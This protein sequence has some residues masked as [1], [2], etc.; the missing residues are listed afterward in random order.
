MDMSKLTTADKRILIA[1]VVVLVGGLVSIIDAWGIGG[2]VGGLAALGVVAVILQPQLSPAMKL[3]APKATLLFGLG[4]V[5]AI[6][7]IVSALQYIE[8]LY[9]FGRLYTLLFEV[10][11]VASVVLAYL[12]WMNYKAHGGMAAAP[13]TPAPPVTP[14]P[15]PAE[16]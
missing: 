3:P 4:A 16:G 14:P 9:N 5:A 12:T 10:G 1:G 6:G 2:I 15:P 7:F 13:A 8:Y 11:V